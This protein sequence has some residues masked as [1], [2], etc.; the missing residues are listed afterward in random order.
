MLCR[1]KKYLN[2]RAQNT[3]PCCVGRAAKQIRK[4]FIL[5][6]VGPIRRKERSRHILSTLKMVLNLSSPPLLPKYTVPGITY[7]PSTAP[8]LPREF[9]FH[10]FISR[11]S[12]RWSS[13]GRAA[14]K[15][16]R[17]RKSVRKP[18]PGFDPLLI[19]NIYLLKSTFFGWCIESVFFIL[20][21]S[22]AM[23]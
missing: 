21:C 15:P 13:S 1:I 22:I 10:R 2:I 4:R 8:T 6:I 14:R 19:E 16:R 5:I 20:R 3:K 12:L 11:F 17:K 23:I 9:M 7:A 18:V